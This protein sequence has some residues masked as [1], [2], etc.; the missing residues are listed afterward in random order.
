[1]AAHKMSAEQFTVCGLL[2]IITFWKENSELLSME[3]AFHRKSSD[4]IGL[5][6]FALIG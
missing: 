1:M 3:A 2:N 5:I 4:E 6:S